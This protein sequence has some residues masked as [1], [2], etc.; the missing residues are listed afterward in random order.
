[1]SAGIKPVKERPILFSGPLIRALLAGTKT[2][3]RRLVKPQPPPPN[4]T[5]SFGLA[6]A[7]A[8][9]EKPDLFVVV[10][11]VWAVREHDPKMANAGIRCPFGVPG[12]RLWV[13]E[14][15]ALTSTWDKSRPAEMPVLSRLGRP[16][17]PVRWR[18]DEVHEGALL[19]WGRWRPSIHM[20]RWA[21]R[22]A[23][24]VTGV[25]VERLQEITEDDAKAEGVP[26]QGIGNMRVFTAMGA[27]RYH[28]ATLWDQI[29]GKRADWMSNPW[30]WVVEFRRLD[31]AERAA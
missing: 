18:A 21:S 27:N 9:W 26:D 6:P 19:E 29:N 12:D 30:V 3:T 23:L 28:F 2:Q 25:R 14:T 10:G 13:R 7:P 4:P 24:E 20:P 1:M 17:I 16:E 11:D 31:V 15:Y 8:S 22:L 5:G